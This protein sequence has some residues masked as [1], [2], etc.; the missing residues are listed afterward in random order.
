MTKAAQTSSIPFGA[1]LRRYRERAGL[2]QEELAE[3]AGVTS[4]AIGALERGVRRH[5]YPTTVRRLAEALGLTEEERTELLAA[6]PPRGQHPETV[7]SVAGGSREQPSEQSAPGIVSP[8]LPRPLTPLVGREHEVEALAGLLREGRRLLTLTGPGGVGKTRLAL[9]VVSAIRP[10]FADGVAFVPLAPLTEAGLVLSTIAQVLGVRE[11]GDQPLDQVLRRALSGRRLLLV[12]DNC[13]HVLSGVAAVVSLVE[14]CPQL[15]VLATSRAP[16]RVLGEQEYP[17]GPLPLPAFERALTREDA[18]RSP[19][20]QLFVERAQAAKPEFTLTEEYAPAVAAICGRLDGLPLALELVAPRVKILRPPALLSRL[21]HALPLLTGGG[22]DAPER[23]QTLRNTLDWSYRLLSPQEQAL[24]ARLSVFVGGCAFEAVE[25]VC[26]PDVDLDVL[27]SL[28]GLLDQSLLRREGEDEPRFGMLETIREYAQERLEASGE[29]DVLRRR[30]ASWYLALAEEVATELPRS[31]QAVWLGRLD[32]EHGNLR[33]ALHWAQESGEVELGLRLAA[34]LG[35]F[36]RIRGHLTEG[37]RWLTTLLDMDAELAPLPRAAALLKMGELIFAQGKERDAAALFERSLALYRDAGDWHG[38]SEALG[39]LAD[40]MHH[41][42]DDERAG[43]LLTEYVSIGRERGDQALLATALCRLAMR[44][45]WRDDFPQA[46]RL[47]EE[48]LALFRELGNVRGM[49]NALEI[50]AV[51]AYRAGDIAHGRAVIEEMIALLPQSGL[52]QEL[53]SWNEVLA[54]EARDQGDY[55]HAMRWLEALEARARELGDRR[56][57]AH[58]RE[59]LGRLARE[60][61]DYERARTLLEES[62]AVFQETQDLRGIG[63]ALVGLSD[64]ARDHGDPQGVI[65]PCR[66]ALD[67]FRQTR[68]A[69]Y[70]GLVLHNLGLAA[71]S[72]GDYERAETLLAES[73][74]ALRHSPVSAALAE[75]LTAVGLVALEQ[76]QH[77]RA[78]QAFVESL[79]TERT[80]TLG[81]VLEALAGVAVEQ[82]HPERA[83]RLFGAAAAIRTKMGTPILPA[84]QRM[85]QRHVTLSQKALGEELMTR[86]WAEGHAMTREQAVAYALEQDSAPGWIP[87]RKGAA[88]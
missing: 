17:V 1:L 26:N 16:L 12:L 87:R 6:V 11:S 29:R 43:A 41:Q 28:S 13:E 7:R 10:L 75:V 50:A 69:F 46:H 9:E 5:P 71:R 30:H 68:N 21:H 31:H 59:V 18:V 33:A 56:H 42:G 76:G 72:Q 62:L 37:Q 60:Q 53:V 49:M 57:V 48:C 51:A 55:G 34:A 24:L 38:S 67:L 40:T 79:R 45:A 54:W 8:A 78:H 36:W 22:R 80:W 20:V 58:V 27:E 4:Q 19:A 44:A 70:T 86:T 47:G 32:A 63:S 52:D 74:S 81:T 83:A 14:S 82:G 77:D 61:G 88:S 23:Q 2:S 66:Q 3:R 39:R 73:L 64:I 65:E 15:V 84:N 25:G 85:Y 35:R